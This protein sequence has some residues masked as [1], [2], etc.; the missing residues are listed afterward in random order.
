MPG[1]GFA[2]PVRVCRKKDFRSFL[3]VFLDG[4]DEVRLTPDVD[5]FGLEIVFDI[6]A[7]RALGKIA[8]MARA[9]Y[10]VIAAAQEF[11]DGPGLGRGLYDH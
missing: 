2:L 10:H 4:L 11:T 5:V 8:E 9:R 7:Q 3:R 1:D 6:H